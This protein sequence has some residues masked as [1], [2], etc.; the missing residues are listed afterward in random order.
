MIKLGN[1]VTIN[2]IDH[3][4]RGISTLYNKTVFVENAL[5]TEEVKINIT[6]NKKNYF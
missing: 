3:F 2:R 4:G 6:N 1:K 5:P